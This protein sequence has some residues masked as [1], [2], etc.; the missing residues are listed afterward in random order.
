MNHLPTLS[1]ITSLV[2]SL[3][4]CGSQETPT[5]KVEKHT[6]TLTPEK[7]L[8]A[9][10]FYIKVDECYKMLPQLQE[11]LYDLGIH[12]MIPYGK[13]EMKGQNVKL[14]PGA[15]VVGI[16]GK[17]AVEMNR[18]P[19][20]KGGNPTVL[21]WVQAVDL[22]EDGLC[23]GAVSQVYY[24]SNSDSDYNY[25][26]DAV[27]YQLSLVL[28]IKPGLAHQ[29]FVAIGGT[30]DMD[31]N[32]FATSSDTNLQSYY[33]D[34]IQ[35]P[36]GDNDR[37]V[38]LK[39]YPK[40]GGMP[41]I[42]LPT[43]PLV[44]YSRSG[45]EFPEPEF[46][47]EGAFIRMEPTK[48]E[49]NGVGGGWDIIRW[50]PKIKKFRN[51]IKR[52][53]PIFSPEN[54]EYWAVRAWLAERYLD[55]GLKA[56]KER[57]YSTA[58]TLLE[59]AASTDPRNL[60]ILTWRA[61]FAYA[62]ARYKEAAAFYEQVVLRDQYATAKPPLDQTWFDLGLSYEAQCWQQVRER[63]LG[64]PQ[65]CADQALNKAQAAYQTYLKLAPNGVRA[66]EVRQRLQDM[67]KGVFHT[68]VGD[69]ELA[70][71]AQW[72]DKLAKV[73]VQASHGAARPEAPAPSAGTGP[74]QGAKQADVYDLNPA[75]LKKIDKEIGHLLQMKG[76]SFE[77]SRIDWMIAYKAKFPEADLNDMIARPE[78]YEALPWVKAWR[79]AY[80]SV[81]K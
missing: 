3:S 14:M 58:E 78:Y 31:E 68:P 22:N 61:H 59:L 72:V 79:K 17:W 53:D 29:D 80:S 41:F 21:G 37:A 69:A 43:Y 40:S 77:Q 64:D 48:V 44:R 71:S 9:D 18:P 74:P 55:D 11:P 32:Y 2:L 42:L 24:D 50:D 20:R 73:F 13:G 34:N 57:E 81:P 10:A 26:L 19:S 65:G 28:H 16:S 39:I 35:V 62:S 30:A 33:M 12:Q 6:P 7:G 52:Y 38:V 76:L 23:D 47:G 46:N 27:G 49:W 1:I 56:F 60:D 67:Q 66:A 8:A 4:A 63:K 54:A 25:N 36:G 51:V 75:D 15:E 70:A 45:V 5:L